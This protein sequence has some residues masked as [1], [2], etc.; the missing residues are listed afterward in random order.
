MCKA[1]SRLLPIVVA[2]LGSHSIMTFLVMGLAFIG[3]GLTSLN[4]L[5]LIR[6]NIELVYQHGSTR[7]RVATAS[8]IDRLGC[9]G[10]GHVSGF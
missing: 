3:F 5:Y 8:G 1:A 9:V 2:Y 7:W 4:L 6:A 10:I